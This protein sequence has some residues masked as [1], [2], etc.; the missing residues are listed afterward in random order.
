[1]LSAPFEI[2]DSDVPLAVTASIGIAEGNRETPDKLLRDADIALYQAKAAGKHCAV[3]FSP[4]M[5]EVVDDHRHLE[6]DLHR[7]LENEQFFLLY[8]PTVDLA[9]GAFT[10]VEALIRWHHPE[11][12]MVVPDEFVP[13]LEA[14]GLIVPVGRWVLE[15]ACRQGAAWQRQ[16]HRITM[17]VNVSVVQLERDQIVDEV[18][19]AIGVSGLDPTMLVLELTETALMRDVQ[20]TLVRLTMLKAIGVGIAIDDFGTGYSSL[21][22][23][24]QFP[25]DLLKI[26]RSFVSSIT[27]SSES[28]AIVH[29]LVQ[30]GKVLELKVI[31]E[32]IENDDQLSK[33]RAE[34]VD[35][36]QG[37]LFARP[38]D[39]EA[40]DRLLK[41]TTRTA[42]G[43][44][45]L[46]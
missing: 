7:A 24:R 8:Q 17:S 9:T 35:I 5:Q 43:L 37:F 42:T 46:T 19:A 45:V 40:V 3:L 39:V 1:V 23:L 11:R 26:D 20:A 22:Y 13:A 4:A 16:G 21:A 15:A 30:L 25:I 2:S 41:D 18:R 34:H 38:L 6:V 27:E 29:T 44:R 28:A 32:G 31:A 14:S 10:G 33:L 12:G 36:G